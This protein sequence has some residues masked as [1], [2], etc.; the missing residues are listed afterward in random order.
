MAQRTEVSFGVKN[1]TL[2]IRFYTVYNVEVKFLTL[3]PQCT[4]LFLLVF[5][6]IAFV[7]Y[8]RNYAKGV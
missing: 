7:L 5:L 6:G 1:T 8:I 2:S 3:V 4:S